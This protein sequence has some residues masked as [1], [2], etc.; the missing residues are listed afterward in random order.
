MGKRGEPVAVDALVVLEVLAGDAQDIVVFAGHEIA[1]QHVEH[2]FDS[3]LEL[4]ER[5]GELARR[6]S[7]RCIETFW[8]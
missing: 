2:A 1:D 5:L 8:L 4:G 7:A 6:A 3:G